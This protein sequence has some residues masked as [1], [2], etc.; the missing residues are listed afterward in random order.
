MLPGVALSKTARGEEQSPLPVRALL[1]HGSRY[2][3]K[4]V[5]K[6][7]HE[8]A[9]SVDVGLEVVETMASSGLNTL[10]VDLADGV[11]Y[12]SHP[13]LRRH[14]SVP[15]AQLEELSSRCR[16]LDLDFVPTSKLSQVSFISNFKLLKSFFF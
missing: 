8:A 11:E 6:K 1:I 2:D 12:R 15:M 4:W 7:E 16:A 3:P 5:P 13:E 14:Y 9:F 10:I